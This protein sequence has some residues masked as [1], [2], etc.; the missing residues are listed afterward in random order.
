MRRYKVLRAYSTGQS[1]QIEVRS[2]RKHKLRQRTI[3]FGKSQRSG[4]GLDLHVRDLHVRDLLV[5]DLARPA[6][7]FRLWPSGLL[8]L[9]ASLFWRRVVSLA[10]SDPN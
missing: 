1:G 8:I 10:R 5:R 7:L 9:E 6:N 4:D 3:F 2:F